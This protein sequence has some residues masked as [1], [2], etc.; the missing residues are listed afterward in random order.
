MTVCGTPELVVP[1]DLLTCEKASH[2]QMRRQMHV[3][4]VGLKPRDLACQVAQLV[5]GDAAFRERLIQLSLLLDDRDTQGDGLP[6]HRL[7]DPSDLTLL[8]E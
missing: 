4:Q 8:L 3:P 7:L 6:P 5:L 2:L 1:G